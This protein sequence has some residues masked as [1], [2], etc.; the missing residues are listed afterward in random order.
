MCVTSPASKV[1]LTI[2]RM[3]AGALFPSIVCCILSKCYATRSGHPWRVVSP[4]CILD[5]FHH[6]LSSES[7]IHTLCM[8]GLRGLETVGREGR[9]KW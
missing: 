8:R 7:N 6:T 3:S 5:V 2:S 9:A 1:L 4:T